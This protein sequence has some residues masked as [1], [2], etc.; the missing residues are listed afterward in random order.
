MCNC[1]Y[2]ISSDEVQIMKLVRHEVEE[3]IKEMCELRKLDFTPQA[4][5]SYIFTNNVLT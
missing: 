5:G 2:K 1:E 4:V 3:V